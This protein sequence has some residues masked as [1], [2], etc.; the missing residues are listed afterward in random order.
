MQRCRGNSVVLFLGDTFFAQRGPRIV[1]VR[2]I[3]P[4]PG[5]AEVATESAIKRPFDLLRDAVFTQQRAVVAIHRLALPATL[6]QSD[7]QRELHLTLL[8]HVQ[9]VGMLHGDEHALLLR[10]HQQMP[11]AADES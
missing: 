11:V 9:P 1:G 5:S 6:S 10:R 7:G 3:Q 8:A 2:I 4:Q